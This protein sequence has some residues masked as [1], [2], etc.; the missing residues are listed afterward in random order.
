MLI[1]QKVARANP[2]LKKTRSIKDCSTG[3]WSDE[4]QIV[5]IDGR[6][7]SRT[8]DRRRCSRCYAA[9]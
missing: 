8:G 4:F 2:V 9:R 1:R 6:R 5:Q 7:N 3:N